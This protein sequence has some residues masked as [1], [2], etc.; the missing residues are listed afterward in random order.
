VNRDPKAGRNFFLNERHELTPGEKSGGFGQQPK[1]GVINWSDRTTALKQGFSRVRDSARTS[2]DPTSTRRFFMVAVPAVIPRYSD[3][4]GRR[5][6]FDEPAD[7]RDKRSADLA[8]LGL[9]LLGVAEDGRAL[10]H[11]SS[12]R[13][14]MLER[15]AS[16]LATETERGRNRWLALAN[17][18]VPDWRMRVDRDW[19]TNLGDGSGEC[20]VEAMPVLT[21]FE[22]DAVALRMFGELGSGVQVSGLGADYS[23]R[24]WWRCTL[25]RGQVDWILRT[26]PSVQMVH[27]PYGTDFA[28]EGGAIG[29]PRH[30]PQLAP[31]PQLADLPVVAIVDSGV[32]PTHPSLA[33][34]RVGRWASPRAITPGFEH[35][36]SF[37]ATRVVFGRIRSEGEGSIR[38]DCAFYDVASGM[39]PTSAGPHAPWQLDDKD[40]VPSMAAALGAFPDVRT[41]VCAFDTQPVALLSEGERQEKLRL[42]RELDTFIAANDVVVVVS[43]GNVRNEVQPQVP[44][45]GHFRDA[46]WRLGPWAS[47]HN[48][49]TCGGFSGADGE[50]NL[51][52][53]GAPSP[54][55]RVGPGFADAYGAPASADH[56]GGELGGVPVMDD[57]GRWFNRMGTSFSAPLLGREAARA[58]KALQTYCPSGRVTSALVKAFLTLKAEPLGTELSAKFKQLL[59]QATGLGRMTAERLVTPGTDTAVFLWQGLIESP[60]DTVRVILPVPRAWLEKVQR[61]VL[62]IAMAWNSPVNENASDLWSCRRVEG[63]LRSGDH[64]GKALRPSPHQLGGTYPRWLRSYDLKS[65]DVEPVVD[66]Q[67]VLSISYKTDQMAPPLPFL[68]SGPA[69]AVAFAAELLDASGRLSPFEA[70]VRLE[71]RVGLMDRLRAAVVPVPIVVRT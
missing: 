18:E 52:P 11:A 70:V 54:F 33:S 7:F 9:D 46:R 41:F 67:L 14:A 30:V 25:N 34:Y 51:A 43:A 64:E 37:V 58:F 71:S 57:Y 65:G 19:L 63:A 45:P 68:P 50:S 29:T 15:T 69:Q 42:V 24:R 39:K 48:T 6:E 22:A 35:H 13:F 12:E 62:R 20:I 47:A 36:G 4:D 59:K 53:P 3:K 16:S 55:S 27:P 66:D 10:V 28:A 61:P 2:L 60:D 56:A 5:E 40:I 8:R 31:P 49:L 32:S 1:L 44:Y 21:P 23:G 17:V 38:G 26:F